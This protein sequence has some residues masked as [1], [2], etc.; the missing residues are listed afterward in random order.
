MYSRATNHIRN[1]YIFLLMLGIYIGLVMTWYYKPPWFIDHLIYLHIATPINLT[2]LNFWHDSG[3]SV[4]PGHHNERWAVL[5]PIMI[6]EKALFFLTPGTSSQVLIFSIYLGIFFFLYRIIRLNNGNL[7][8]NLFAILFVLAVHHTKNRATEILADPFGV[9]YF[10]VAIYILSKYKDRLGFLQFFIVGGLLT[11]AT[12][13]KIHYGIFIIIFLIWFR[14]DI[15][16]I[17]RPLIFGSI[18]SI[19]FLDLLLFFF[20]QLDIFIQ[21]NKNTISVLMGYL[22]GGLG[23]SDGPGN[24]GWSYEWLKLIA[25]NKFLPI[26]LMV[27]TVFLASRGLKY[28]TILAWSSLS[29]FL[30][31]IVL[32]SVSNFP[33]NSSYAFPV[34]VFSVAT[35]AIIISEF[36]PKIINDNVFLLVVFFT[37]AVALYAI[38]E[39]GSVKSSKFFISYKSLSIVFSLVVFSI[40]VVKRK[41]LAVFFVFLVIFT[42]DIFWHNWKNIENHSWWRHGYNWHYDYLDVVKSFN[43]EDGVYQVHFKDWPRIKK[44]PGREKMY[45]E[46]GIRSLNRSSIDIY[47]K[48]G[49]GTLSILDSADFLLT[50][51]SVNNANFRLIKQKEFKTY[52]DKKDHNLNLYIRNK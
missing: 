10:V 9:L 24:N 44:R 6:A 42:S 32:S 12:F 14:S 7:A 50:D 51:Y 35:G 33:A 4:N 37:S 48:V 28:S 46:P 21:V 1:N 38:S 17:Y 45:I 31:I 52:P 23:V 13:T 3:V 30:L 39:L 36:K 34:F 5:V 16:K 40:L 8:S 41:T 20:L 47:S 18:F 26:T 11:L 29:F 15:I 22:S 27:S 2:D 19:I 49:D 25:Q 43:L